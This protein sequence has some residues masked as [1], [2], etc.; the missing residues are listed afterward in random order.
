MLVQAW[1]AHTAQRQCA[2]TCLCTEY[3]TAQYCSGT[4]D[5]VAA[6]KAT[7]LVAVGLR[8]GAHAYKDGG[9]QGSGVWGDKAFHDA[10][11]GLLDKVHTTVHE[12][13]QQQS[14]V[15]VKEKETVQVKEKETVK[16]KT[17]MVGLCA[18]MA[19]LQ[20]MLEWVCNIN[21]NGYPGAH[22]IDLGCNVRVVPG[23]LDI[24]V[25]LHITSGPVFKL[26]VNAVV[27]GVSDVLG[28]IQKI[29]AMNEL[30][31][32]LGMNNGGFL[33][34]S[35]YLDFPKGFGG[36]GFS[37][38]LDLF[39][40]R[41]KAHFHVFLRFNLNAPNAIDPNIQAF[42]NMGWFGGPT[43]TICSGPTHLSNCG[44]CGVDNLN[45]YC[46]SCKTSPVKFAK[47]DITLK[48]E[49]IEPVWGWP[50]FKYN[51]FW[52]LKVLNTGQKY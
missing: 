39:A 20:Y 10:L 25:S 49:H 32:S 27:P 1:D 15:Q 13:H 33:L 29:P 2:E 31:S 18:Q 14:L 16:T 21:C 45:H 41:A 48:A 5:C 17:G 7:A 50:P 28:E 24:N 12:H 52:Y 47:F 34:G 44:V 6:V 37:S 35:G 51:E 26:T 40:V 9:V 43:S 3:G 8:T 30:M 4:P 38:G 36:L 19:Y 11:H 22:Q 23:L 46:G 42:C